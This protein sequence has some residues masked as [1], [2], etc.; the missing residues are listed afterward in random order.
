MKNMLAALAAMSC[1]LMSP[2]Q[3]AD[4][5][6]P[7]PTAVVPAGASCADLA[8]VALADIGGPGSRVTSA[9]EGT[10]NG[11]PACT[12]EATLAPSIGLRLVLPRQTWTQRF[13]Q[14]G[15]GGLCG[16]IP[17]E[18][19]AADGCVP[20][21]AG[22]FAIA[23]TDMGHQGNSAEFGRDP[24]QRADFAWRGVHLTAL[25]SKKL[26]KAFY[27]RAPSY[28]YFNGCSDG[29]REALVE[30]QRFP[31][32]FDGIL[33]GAAAMNFQVQNGIY[34]AWQARANTGADGKAILVAAR[35]P[36]L[37]QAVLKQCDKL[38]GQADGLIAD[39]RACRVD[40]A[41]L[42]CKAGATDT[43]ACLTAPEAEAARRLYEG[44]RDPQTGERL[45]AGGPMPGSELGW[46]GV[47]VPRSANDPIFSE[48]IA[49][50]ALR[51]M[52]FEDNPPAD[53]KLADLRFDKATFQRLRARHPL[54]DATNPD[55]SAFAARGGKLIV[56]HGWSD[57]HISPMNAIAYHEALHKRMG[58]QAASFE[59][60]Y[61]LPGV[62]HCGGGEGPSSVDFLTPM[63][64]WVERGI[65]PR[66]VTAR[67]PAPGQGHASFGQPPALAGAKP[68]GPPPGAPA[69]AQA[70][71]PRAR[72]LF[73]YPAV[74]RYAGKGSED[75]AASYVED[76]AL[77]AGGASD[78]L[79][80][81][82]YQPY[83][84][85]QE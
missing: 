83:E 67:T 23:S 35:L 50:G 29:G 52:I 16:R 55:L 59:R 27:G 38:D 14:V 74:A 53:F 8:K 82:F 41:A 26:I 65:A 57:P 62:Y 69:E 68:A 13:M 20:L 66:A 70:S 19:G 85:R 43:S 33:A 45:T 34:H 10:S 58:A 11:A 77:T 36:V 3:A 84:A 73:P 49:L 79:G 30:A 56:W 21:N 1:L 12:V 48:M 28:S 40:L 5:P 71:R 25:A 37:H 51:N 78:W 7:R 72:P 64:E 76:K 31:D 6:A 44:P 18:V 22:G 54:F 4:K 24:Q 46:A 60:L 42:Q 75:D 47:F 81:D 61:L 63:M 9:T 15:C 80:A 39:P 32:D 2:A 17:T